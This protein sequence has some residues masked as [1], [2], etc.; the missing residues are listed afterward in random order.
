M[1]R[2]GA[3]GLDFAVVGAQLFEG[4]AGQ[5]LIGVAGLSVSA[6]RAPGGD[7]RDLRLA[8]GAQVECV[9]LVGR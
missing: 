5:E 8:Q 1:S 2:S 6:A 3:H 4:T 7:E 9:D